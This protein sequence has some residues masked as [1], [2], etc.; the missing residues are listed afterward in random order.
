MAVK[1]AADL[2]MGPLCSRGST[3]CGG[4]PSPSCV[5]PG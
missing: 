1:A 2:D 4:L 5:F 3:F